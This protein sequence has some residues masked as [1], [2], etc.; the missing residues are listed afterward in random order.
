MIA[1]A[2]VDAYGESE[3]RTAWGTVLDDRV[4]TP[5]ESRVLGV[6]VIV[7]GFDVTSAGDVVARCRRGSAR[8]TIPAADLALPDPPPGGAEW[9]AAYRHWARS[10]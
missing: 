7:E 10:T 9:L 5:F 3:R 8:Q 2:L 4:E 1:E 6:T